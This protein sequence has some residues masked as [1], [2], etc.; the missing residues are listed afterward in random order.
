LL[1][2]FAINH[3]LSGRWLLGGT[4]LLA[5]C[6]LAVNAIALHRG[7]PPRV[8]FWA[9]AV[10]LI[11]AVL[12]S[13]GLQGVNGVFWAYPTLFICYFVL[14]RRMA[15][16]LSSMLVL[17]TPLLVAL[18]LSP[19]LAARVA[20]TLLLTLVMINVVL[21]VIGG[22]QQAMLLQTLTDPLTGAYNRRHL[23]AQLAQLLAGAGAGA[24]DTRSVNTLLAIDIDHFK[25][26]NDR[27]GHAKGDEVLKAAVAVLASRKRQ[28]DMLFRTGGEEFVLLLARTT[29]DDALVVAEDLRQRFEQAPLLPGQR[30]TV[31]IGLSTYRRG[32]DA[33]AWLQAADAALY[34]A[35][36]AGRNRVVAT[37]AP[38]EA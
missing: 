21:N 27:H 33:G 34:D 30:V 10:A 6:I 31:S 8:A 25:T 7:Q 18:S 12:I 1:L 28:T 13:I 24:G 14:P 19:A 11:G 37:P 20:A 5:Q 17:S 35:K 9:M 22:L 2:P 4:I 16:M 23:D 36:H 38:Q 15:L 26:I 32:Q 3:G 29:A